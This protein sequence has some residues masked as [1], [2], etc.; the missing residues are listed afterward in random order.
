MNPMN[1]GEILVVL[2]GIEPPLPAYETSVRTILQHHD[3]KKPSKAF[4]WRV[5]EIC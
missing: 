3:N 5:Y 1:N 4:T 2:S